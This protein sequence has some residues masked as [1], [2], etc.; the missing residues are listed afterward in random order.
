M[1]HGRA[2][3][4]MLLF[5][6]FGAAAWAVPTGKRWF[7]SPVEYRVFSHASI[8]GV[9]D[10]TQNVLPG[11]QNAFSSWTQATCTSWNTQYQGPFSLPTGTAAVTAADRLNTVV[12][13]GGSN[14]RYGSATLGLTTLAFLTGSGE[15][16]DADME[17]NN[18]VLW[19]TQA[20][21]TAN[22][23]DMQSVVLHEAGHF[24]GL[25]HTPGS[26]GA[27]MFPTIP[28]GTV[29][30]TLATVDTNDV[31]SVYPK[32]AGGQGSP[33]MNSTECSTGLSCL[34]PTGSSSRICT[35]DCSGGS[36]CPSGYTCQAGDA[37]QA[38]L[39]PSGSTDLCRF[40]TDGAQCASGLCLTNKRNNW[41]SMACSSPAQC[42][43]GY[44]C[45]NGYCVPSSNCTGQCTTS[46]QCAVGFD[47]ASGQCEAKGG[48]GDRCEVT[49]YCSACSL[50]MGN[51]SVAFCRSCCEGQDAGSLCTACANASCGTGL[52]CQS[53]KDSQ[54]N[55]TVDST[56]APDGGT[57]CSACSSSKPCGTGYLCLLGRCR[58]TCN[59]TY[60]ARCAACFDP[61]LGLGGICA[62][63]SETKM[64]GEGCGLGSTGALGVCVAGLKCVGAPAPVCR[65]TCDLNVAG[66]C[67]ADEQ[68]QSVDGQ[69]VCV[70]VVVP[71][72]V[73]APCSNQQCATGLTCFQGRCYYACDVDKPIC[74][75]CV[76]VDGGA[77]LCACEDQR[78]G[79]DEACGLVS[80]SQLLSCRTGYVCSAGACRQACN[81]QEP[82]CPE[83]TSCRHFDGYSLCLSSDV[84]ADGGFPGL[85]PVN[86]GCG[87]VAVSS[88][89][90][91]L[92]FGAGF[93]WAARFRRRRLP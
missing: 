58:A 70:P 6:L 54:G 29:K 23:Y 9:T 91:W 30:R 62:C 78:A 1:R 2:A 3:A 7:K 18:N 49:A 10:F 8:N 15:I 45:T 27:V 69:P 34:G 82:N 66:S 68:C 50:C 80:S 51:E 36:A 86:N 31:C 4:S 47:C 87:C 39:L 22:A 48:V 81:L 52:T 90:S 12:W 43:T 25:D 76:P 77:G 21:G 60:P 40:C 57:F 17:M 46:S 64:E 74:A 67:R 13:L 73:C 63:S 44:N 42:G 26:G 85:E 84:Q 19:S 14:W 33:C 71:G 92:L 93:F 41:C 37:G 75:S 16:L 65:R 72:A 83:N 79:P 28:K 35:V 55:N 32:S 88:D 24:L 59:A 53:I 20:N 11:V 38:C 5:C 89:T 61:G 56:C